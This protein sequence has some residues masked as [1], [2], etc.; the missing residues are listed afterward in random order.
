MYILCVL[1]I[2]QLDNIE[3]L[4]MTL[5]AKEKQQ[6]IGE[7]NR[8][9]ILIVSGM[10]SNRGTS[11][12]S[13]RIAEFVAERKKLRQRTDANV[14][15]PR[16]STPNVPVDVPHTQ[17]NTVSNSV[18]TNPPVSVTLEINTEAN[19]PRVAPANTFSDSAY[20]ALE[21]L[22]TEALAEQSKAEVAVEAARRDL[23]VAQSALNIATNH[24][25][26]ACGEVDRRTACLN[27]VKQEASKHQQ[28]MSRGLR[29]LLEE[30]AADVALEIMNTTKFSDDVHEGLDTDA[31]SLPS[32]HAA[33]NQINALNARR[34]EH[35]YNHLRLDVELLARAAVNA[36]HYS[37][38]GKIINPDDDGITQIVL[39][40]ADDT[41]DGVYCRGVSEL[42]CVCAL[43]G[44][45]DD[46]DNVH[47]IPYA[48]S[49]ML[50]SEIM[51]EYPEVLINPKILA[52][53]A[54]ADDTATRIGIGCC[55]T[56]GASGSG[57]TV[58]LVG[59]GDSTYPTMSAGDFEMVL[60]MFENKLQD[61]LGEVNTAETKLAEAMEEY[62]DAQKT[63]TAARGTVDA[64]NARLQVELATLARAD[65]T[66]SDIAT[67]ITDVRLNASDSGAVA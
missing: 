67:A 61:A 44:I 36:D 49:G 28:R 2:E 56:T 58:I 46:S 5:D 30:L 39:M 54:L 20:A 41:L 45:R 50:P 66:V 13:E 8:G 64:A 16:L 35:G 29:P 53:L 48:A 23:S 7:R 11:K 31:T 55:S 25:N 26:H 51:C 4:E 1:F 57:C 34:V 59:N 60:T 63:L 33:I 6:L 17:G 27:T 43:G 42:K 18:S 40:N 3:T 9:N 21:E 12:Y 14:N 22:M 65:N 10:P 37:N 38:G 62:R 32:L 24:C 47:P 52:Y 15:T 19:T